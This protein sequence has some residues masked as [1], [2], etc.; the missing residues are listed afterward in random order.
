MEDENIKRVAADKHE[1]SPHYRFAHV[2]QFGDIFG[3]QK[4]GCSRHRERQ[5]IAQLTVVV[6]AAPVLRSRICD[7]SEA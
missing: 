1:Q 4:T 3:H 5:Q 2:D 7:D 6:H